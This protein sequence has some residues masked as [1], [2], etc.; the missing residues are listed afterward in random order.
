MNK[1]KGKKSLQP[2]TM[3][4]IILN[5]LTRFD[6]K[7][8]LTSSSSYKKRLPFLLQHIAAFWF[9]SQSF[10]ILKGLPKIPL[11]CFV[12]EHSQKQGRLHPIGSFYFDVKQKPFR[13]SYCFP[14]DLLDT[15]FPWNPIGCVSLDSGISQNQGCSINLGWKKKSGGNGTQSIRGK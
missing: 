14:H 2:V 7:F 6:R 11:F 13:F 1:Q 3:R 5:F 4:K 12:E 8:S 10:G 15:L 9:F